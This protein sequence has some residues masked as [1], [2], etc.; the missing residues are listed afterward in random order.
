LILKTHLL[1]TAH[2]P[3]G[4]S[5]N[6]YVSWR[7]S[8][9]SSSFIVLIYLSLSSDATALLNVVEDA[10]FLTGSLLIAV[11]AHMALSMCTSQYG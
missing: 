3:L 8:D 5:V 2:L 10:V 1:S 4:R 11:K 9:S 6:L 7:R